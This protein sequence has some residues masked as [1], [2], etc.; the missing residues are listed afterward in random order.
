MKVNM[1][2]MRAL[3]AVVPI[4]YQH[5]ICGTYVKWNE[6]NVGQCPSNTE[7]SAEKKKKPQNIKM[8]RASVH[9]GS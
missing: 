9:S 2:V 3:I 8:I 1:R 5:M 4:R 6:K 7:M